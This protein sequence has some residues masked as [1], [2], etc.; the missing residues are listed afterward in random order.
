[1]L[2]MHHVNSQK[3]TFSEN[4]IKMLLDEKENGKKNWQIINKSILIHYEECLVL[5]FIFLC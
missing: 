1:M 2:K 3:P 4:L 5:S